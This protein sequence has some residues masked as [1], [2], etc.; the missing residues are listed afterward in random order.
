[1]AGRVLIVKMIR[2]KIN[3]KIMIKQIKVQIVTCVLD[4][5]NYAEITQAYSF[6]LVNLNFFKDFNLNK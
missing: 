3:K 4:F 1:M 2:I 6:Y 5:S